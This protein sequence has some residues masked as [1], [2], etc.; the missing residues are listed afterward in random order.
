MKFDGIQVEDRCERCA[1]LI[2][3]HLMSFFTE[4]AICQDCHDEERRLLA[5]LRLH[6]I[7]P[8]TLAGCGYLPA[9]DDPGDARPPMPA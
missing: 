5:R 6:G 1:Q 4:E 9:E 7:A 3:V 8:G 2:S